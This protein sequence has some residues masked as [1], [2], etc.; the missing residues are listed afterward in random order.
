ML[1]AKLTGMAVAIK[2]HVHKPVGMVVMEE[3]LLISG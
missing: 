3:M 2:V 1:V